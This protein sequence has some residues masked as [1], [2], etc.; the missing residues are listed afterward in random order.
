[1]N[2]FGVRFPENF[3]AIPETGVDCGWQALR[4]QGT[5]A[6]RTAFGAAWI[7]GWRF[8]NRFL[9]IISTLIL[10]R[11]LVPADFGVVALAMG[12]VQG[13]Q[14]L[15]ELGTENAI[16]RA[17]MPDR[18]LYNTGFT[19]NVLRG[20]G[21]AVILLIIAVPAGHFFN[22][23]HFT[24]VTF[25]AA[26]VSAISSLQNIGVV[27]YRRYMAFDKEFL[28][29]LLPR[30]ISVS[31]AISLAFVLRDYWALIIAILVSVVVDTLLS[32]VLHPYRPGLTLA[33]WPRMASYSTLLWLSN[34]A[35]L[36][37]GLGT[38][39]TITK[40]TNVGAL[41][42]FE[43]AHE[44]AQLPSSELVG[45]LTRAMFSGL[46]EVRTQADRGAS[47]LIKMMTTMN[48]VVMPLGV[49]LSLVAE[50]AIRL[51]FGEKWLGAVPL[52]QVLALGARSQFSVR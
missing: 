44:V 4:K 42:L 48:L 16:I 31:T 24:Q 30:L 12:F 22:S 50:P 18:Q 33:G 32:Y 20:F 51:A 47:L 46:S 8:V 11:L 41:G 49:G 29:K 15:A 39:S 14:Q 35:G 10:V 5:V 7:I 40:M 13:L 34:I 52:L 36:L 3:N 38:K 19:I 21:V 28:L 6:A 45:P 17:D 25:V 27:D 1:M 43:V 9:G 26:A 37:G 23:P 2:W